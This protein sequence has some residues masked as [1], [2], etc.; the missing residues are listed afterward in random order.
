M[1]D[2]PGAPAGAVLRGPRGAAVR[3]DARV[4]G[5]RA[6]GDA[7][8]GGH[9]R[10]AGGQRVLRGGRVVGGAR[11]G[12]GR[13]RRARRDRRAAPVRPGAPG[14]RR[15]RQRDQVERGRRAA[16]AR[17]HDPV[18]LREVPLQLRAH[19]VVLV[20]TGRRRLINQTEL[21]CT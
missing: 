20:A 4:P 13:G 11:A 6:V 7:R 18:P 9:A 2:R 19:Q 10:G 8:G 3:R 1:I 21:A 12:A 15:R 16:L 14:R 5:A 17:E